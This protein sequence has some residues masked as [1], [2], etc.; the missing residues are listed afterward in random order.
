[1]KNMF[2]KLTAEEISSLESNGCTA[3]DWNDVEVS[4]RFD[5]TKV[6]HAAFSGTCRL[7]AFAT[8]FQCPGG[9]FKPAGIYHAT[10][11]NVTVGDDC[12]LSNVRSYIANY[13]IGAGT[14]S[15]NV[16]KVYVDSKTSF[17]NGVE[18]SL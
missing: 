4:P 10:L 9:V 5:A 7:G 8:A 14:H 6:S 13:D 16:D 15:G 12:R 1:M 17:G 3:E 11:H 2:R 18:V